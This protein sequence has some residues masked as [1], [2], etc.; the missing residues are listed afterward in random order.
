MS[1]SAQHRT[2]GAERSTS[3]PRAAPA[4]LTLSPRLDAD[5]RPIAPVPPFPDL[6]HG[7]RLVLYPIRTGLGVDWDLVDMNTQGAL[8]TFPDYL[9]A[10]KV[11]I[12]LC[13]I[14]GGGHMAIIA[15]TEVATLDSDGDAGTRGH[16]R[17]A[18]P[19]EHSQFQ[20]E[21]GLTTPGGG[22]L[23]LL[24]SNRIAIG[25]DQPP[26]LQPAGDF[27]DGDGEATPAQRLEQAGGAVTGDTPAASRALSDGTVTTAIDRPALPWP[28]RPHPDTRINDEET[29]ADPNRSSADDLSARRVSHPEDLPDAPQSPT[30]GIDSMPTAAMFTTRPPTP[31]LPGRIH[32]VRYLADGR[33]LI[34]TDPDAT[35]RTAPELQSDP[36]QSAD[37]GHAPGQA[38]SAAAASQK[39]AASPGSGRETIAR[40][41]V[42]SDQG[43]QDDR[44]PRPGSGPITD[45]RNA[46][47]IGL[48]AELII[49]GHAP[50]GTLLDLG[51]HP[52]RVGPGGRFQLRIPVPEHDR[53]MALL[54]QLPHL[55]VD[56]RE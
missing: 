4:D 32:A 47:A 22:W 5:G 31:D 33:V 53:I 56:E 30:L 40:S 21:L 2:S 19:G 27:S 38:A 29:P 55:P 48:S 6:G 34:G 8:A 46:N 43:Q 7:P 26:L 3:A 11:G 52:Y 28:A 12:R 10:P 15:Q 45:Q 16:Y 41:S 51:G 44:S 9:P 39:G 17:F 54:R 42:D 20:A 36:P 23:L 18:Q 14:G 24:R 25:A 37:D 35:L 50:P 49:S 1:A 13:R